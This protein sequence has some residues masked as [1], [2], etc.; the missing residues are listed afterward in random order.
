MKQ[1]SI[2][3]LMSFAPAP[4]T[5]GGAAGQNTLTLFDDGDPVYNGGVYDMGG[6]GRPA[7]AGT[8][9]GAPYSGAEYLT[10]WGDGLR[11]SP[12]GSNCRQSSR[13]AAFVRGDVGLDNTQDWYIQL[14]VTNDF[15]S[16]D[17]YFIL[18]L[19]GARPDKTWLNTG[20]IR[21]RMLMY[22]GVGDQL[23]G[24]DE[25]AGFAISVDLVAGGL[26]NVMSRGG[27]RLDPVPGTKQM[28]GG[29]NR[30]DRARVC[31]QKG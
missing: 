10:I 3:Y 16:P 31:A 18:W 25:R 6:G 21:D 28:R 7:A 13:L 30:G 8:P 11:T 26:S 24:N 1:T 14:D 29:Y 19:F 20:D 12:D 27:S 5:I 17:Y 9:T 23:P 15:V 4:L 2:V 22:L